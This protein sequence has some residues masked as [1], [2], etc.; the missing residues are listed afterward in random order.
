MTIWPAYASFSERES[1]SLT[2]G[3][4]ADFVILDQDIMRIPTELIL[5][6]QV[7][8]TYLGGKAVYQRP[9]P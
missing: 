3:K 8:A 9:I 1:G 2:P 5:K 7:L 4:V 6:T